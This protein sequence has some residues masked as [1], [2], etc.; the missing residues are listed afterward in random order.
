MATLR[1]I[2][3]TEWRAFF[4]QMSKALLGKRAEVE[5]ASLDLGDQVIVEW[6]PM[7]GIT[8]EPNDDVLDVALDGPNHL[9]RGPQQ[10]AVDEAPTGISSIA[11]T[12]A[13]GARHIIR[14]KAPVMLTGGD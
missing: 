9:I 5:V 2:P 11:V 10:I 12:A 4:D 3:K 13:D 7:I 14:L 1:T 8:Y 6:M